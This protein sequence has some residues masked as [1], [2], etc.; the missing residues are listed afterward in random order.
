MKFLLILMTAALCAGSIYHFSQD[1]DPGTV[2]QAPLEPDTVI[3]YQVD[4]V[5]LQPDTPMHDVH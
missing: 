1:P 3:I 2:P 4:T 5:Y